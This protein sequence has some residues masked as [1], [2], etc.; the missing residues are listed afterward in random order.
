MSTKDILALVDLICIRMTAKPYTADAVQSC[1][2]IDKLV[3]DKLVGD[4]IIGKID[5]AEHAIR[6]R[7][8]GDVFHIG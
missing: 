5:R 4:E 2:Y 7:D 8:D 6:N 3:G 1:E